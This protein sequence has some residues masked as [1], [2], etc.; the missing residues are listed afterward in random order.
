[1]KILLIY[2]MKVFRHQ[3][4]AAKFY[5]HRT[6]DKQ[7]PIQWTAS[8]RFIEME[9]AIIQLRHN[10]NFKSPK[11]IKIHHQVV[12]YWSAFFFLIFDECFLFNT[13]FENEWLSPL[14]PMV[15]RFCHTTFSRNSNRVYQTE[16]TFVFFFLFWKCSSEFGKC[17][18]IFFYRHSF[19]IHLFKYPY[20][21]NNDSLTLI[22]AWI[23][24]TIQNTKNSFSSDDWDFLMK[25]KTR[26]RMNENIEVVVL[27]CWQ[28]IKAYD[29][30][31]FVHVCV[32]ESDKIASTL[33][34]MP[35]FW[36]NVIIKNDKWSV[37]NLFLILFRVPAKHG[38][39]FR[40][41]VLSFIGLWLFLVLWKNFFLRRV[42][43]IWLNVFFAYIFSLLSKL[44]IRSYPLVIWFDYSNFFFL[45]PLWNGHKIKSMEFFF[46]F[47][48]YI[49]LFRDR[50]NWIKTNWSTHITSNDRITWRRQ[51]KHRTQID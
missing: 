6:S 32:R 37:I 5:F 36:R 21:N 28:W 46:S 9:K 51:L 39:V 31:D 48:W 7:Y 42:R 34:E 22:G 14:F 4:R 18:V 45:F 24:K 25:K 11:S 44:I 49:F 1:M 20:R 41:L 50:I 23:R 26:Q 13:H 43:R 47:Y 27:N 15:F 3:F 35:N 12:D 33:K 2:L 30:G 38:T 19:V 16:L 29:F 8:N 10:L 40:L 17:E